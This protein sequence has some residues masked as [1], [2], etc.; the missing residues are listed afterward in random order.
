MIQTNDGQISKT[1][2]VPLQL[3][4]IRNSCENLQPEGKLVAES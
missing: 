3:E 4:E 1:L 2:F